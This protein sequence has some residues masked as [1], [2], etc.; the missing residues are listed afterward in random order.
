[1]NR[2]PVWK[3]AIIVLALLLGVV[4]TLPN[5]FGE[6]PA[7]QVSSSKVSAKVDEGTLKRVAEAIEGANV[8][9]AVLTLEGN[10]IKARFETTFK[11]RLFLLVPTTVMWWL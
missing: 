10:S 1:M 5:F 11:Q 4:Y 6:A 9:A 7:V 8:P 3:F 2:Y